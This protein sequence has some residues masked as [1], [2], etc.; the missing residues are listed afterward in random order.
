MPWVQLFSAESLKYAEEILSDNFDQDISLFENQITVEIRDGKQTLPVAVTRRWEVPGFGFEMACPCGASR[1]AHAAA[2]MKLADVALPTFTDPLA[3]PIGVGGDTGF[4][5]V[6]ITSPYA[7]VGLKPVLV[8][9]SKT[10]PVLFR[11]LPFALQK[12]L[13]E[14]APTEEAGVWAIDRGDDSDFLRWLFGL[15]RF[16]FYYKGQ[17]VRVTDNERNLKMVPVENSRAK[18]HQPVV[19]GFAKIFGPDATHFFDGSTLEIGVLDRPGYAPFWHALLHGNDFVK[20][21]DEHEELM[22]KLYPDAWVDF[23]F[24]KAAKAA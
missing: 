8:L 9:D 18:F 11:F 19:D 23:A 12:T 10:G 22:R 15:K 21:M 2:A 4:E 16:N 7:R 6:E 3:Q 20:D 5:I 17:R 14:Q 24:P 1:C 13:P